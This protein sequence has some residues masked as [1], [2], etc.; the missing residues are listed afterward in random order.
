MISHPH[1]TIFIHIPKCAGQSIETAF[2][3][4]LGLDWSTRAPLLLRRNENP[5]LGPERLA[6]LKAHEYIKYHYVSKEIFDDYYKF[7]IVRDPIDRLVSTYNFKLEN[8][9]KALISWQNFLYQWLPQKLE[10]KHFFVAPQCEYVMSESGQVLVDDIF[11]LD[12]LRDDFSKIKTKSGLKSSLKTVNV[13]TKRLNIKDISS[14]DRIFIE[15][16][17]VDDFK[18]IDQAV[19]QKRTKLA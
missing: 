13:S 17:Y 7:A 15:D 3:S 9:W 1:K 11:L 18:M 19:A 6:H 2:L 4:D 10:S 14:E 16:L 5:K 8:K 12:S